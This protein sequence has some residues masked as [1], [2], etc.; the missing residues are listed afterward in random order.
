[1]QAL[2]HSKQ[3]NGTFVCTTRIMYKENWTIKD[4]SFCI[5]TKRN[6]FTSFRPTS[7]ILTRIAHSPT[8]SQ[9]MGSACFQI[10]EMHH[11]DVSVS[12]KELQFVPRLW[13]A[14]V[15]HGDL[16]RGTN[17]HPQ[18]SPTNTWDASCW[19]CRSRCD[20]SPQGRSGVR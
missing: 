18:A 7:I 10:V 1:M 2:P 6:S 19:S 5:R 12:K 3:S 16:K 15:H 13:V 4:I 14:S 9:T 17:T 20:A 8:G 11:K